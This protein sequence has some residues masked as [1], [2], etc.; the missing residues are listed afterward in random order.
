MRPKKS[1]I[2]SKVKSSTKAVVAEWVLPP[3]LT[4]LITG[5]RKARSSTQGQ[6][7]EFQN[8]LDHYHAEEWSLLVE[9]LR[10]ASSYLEFGSGLSTEFVSQSYDCRIRSVDTSADWVELVRKRVR[11][12]VEVLHFDLGPVGEWGR[13]VSYERRRDF[14]GYFEAGFEGGFDPDVI[15]IDGRFRVACF[16]SSLLLASPGTKIVFDDYRMRP[17]YKVVEEILRPAALSSRQAMFVRPDSIDFGQI[18]D[19]R[20][21]FTYVME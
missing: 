8:P 21:N 5:A 4:K 13:P 17:H 18:R 2:A 14:V 11:S 6:L 19:L 7:V 9:A 3:G 1:D 20:E 10:S 12:D 15:L 16:L